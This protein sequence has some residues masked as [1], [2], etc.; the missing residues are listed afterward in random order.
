MLETKDA[1]KV[2]GLKEGASR[3][4][5]ERRY[6]VLFK[7]YKMS[8]S[9][10]QQDGSPEINFEEITDAYNLL[11]GYSVKSAEEQTVKKP[12]PLL[13]KV[14][15][16]EKKA[17]NFIHY[18][19]FHIII[20]IIVLIVLVTTL[21]GCL[22][23]IDP[24]INIALVGEFFYTD[25]EPL[26]QNIKSIYPELK[27]V[28]ID[29]A[30]L[31]DETKGQQEYAMQMKAM[32][33]FAAGDVDIFILDKATFEKFGKQGAF[34]SLDEIAERLQVDKAKNRDYVLKLEDQQ[35][36]HLYGLDVSSSPIFKD[37]EILGDEKI[38]A[39][40]VK[41]RHYDKAVKLMELMLK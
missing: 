14:G 17:E 34:A 12:N 19:K 21:R 38:A 7:K 35:Q 2:L 23:R 3:S 18:Y 33:L 30:M 10:E 1:Y 22:T 9:H 25:S 15:I 5:I 4:E 28:G 6:A 8:K 20:G 40:S 26:K 36:E 27:E 24:D 13:Q 41:S 29:G 37:S 32:V 39:I 11:M 31:S 16:D